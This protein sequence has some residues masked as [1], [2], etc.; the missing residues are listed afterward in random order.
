MIILGIDKAGRGPL[1]GPVV[2]AGFILRSQV[3]IDGLADSK[4]ITE[5][6][7]E[8]LYQQI[9]TQAKVYTIVEISPQQ[10]DELNILQ[11]NTQNYVSSCR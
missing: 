2:A 3:N 8:Y 7:C 6:K 10:I 11:A 4:K 9:I 5:K 1:S